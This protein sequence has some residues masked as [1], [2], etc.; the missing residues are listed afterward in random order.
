MMVFVD[1]PSDDKADGCYLKLGVENDSVVL[2]GPY[3]D[4]NGGLLSTLP[5]NSNLQKNNDGRYVDGDGHEFWGPM[6]TKFVDK[7]AVSL[8]TRACPK[9]PR[10]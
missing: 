10:I 3:S 6:A 1:F 4:S 5:N 8:T 7:S 9:V 2:Y